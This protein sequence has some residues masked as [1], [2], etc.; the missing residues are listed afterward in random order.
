MAV[1]V[2]GRPASLVK[3]QRAA[4][5]VDARPSSQTR[6]EAEVR[7][8][9]ADA[10]AIEG[11]DELLED[12]VKTRRWDLVAERE[13]MREQMEQQKGSQPA[14]WLEGINDLSPGSFD[15]LT[16]TVLFPV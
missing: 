7:E 5:L 14:D 8:A 1:P 4:R 6:T 10:L 9:L 13:R 16:V 2:Y 12:V 3:R 15:M 11:L